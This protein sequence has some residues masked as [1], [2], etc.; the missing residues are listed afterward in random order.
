M[1]KVPLP[2]RVRVRPRVSH[3]R[4]ASRTTV[5]LTP[6]RVASA[7]SEGNRSPTGSSPRSMAP[8]RSASTAS[9]AE[10]RAYLGAE[11]VQLSDELMGV[12]VS[13]GPDDVGRC[14]HRHG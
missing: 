2:V 6:Y 5:R 10:T 12:R 4:S 9:A 13:R 7:A 1:T 11:V 14:D 8:R 3:E